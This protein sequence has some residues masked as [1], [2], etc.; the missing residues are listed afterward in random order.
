MRWEQLHKQKR[1][2]ERKRQFDEGGGE[3]VVLAPREKSKFQIF[4]AKI[5]QLCL[6]LKSRLDAYQVVHTKFGFL[7]NLEH[8]FTVEI[9]AASANL[10]KDYQNWIE[11]FPNVN[12]ALR[13]YLCMMVSNCSG[14]RSFSK[15]KRI[16]NGLRSTMVQERLS[17]LS[18][19]SI[20]HEIL[21]A[22]DFEELIEA[23]AANKARRKA[24]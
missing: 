21:N 1:Q 15:L 2:P 3:D 20:E 18:L 7:S 22:V 4:L 10:V 23:F 13:I 5:G 6:G 8:L 16:K 17:N 11:T 19:M 14:E 12:V 9:K 24:I